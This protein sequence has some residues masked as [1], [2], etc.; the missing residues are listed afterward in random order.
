[1][2]RKRL[3]EVAVVFLLLVGVVV[4]YV[5]RKPV[6]DAYSLASDLPSTTLSVDLSQGT[7]SYT[8]NGKSQTLRVYSIIPPSVEE[9]SQSSSSSALV[10]ARIAGGPLGLVPGVVQF[11]GETLSVWWPTASRLVNLLSSP[12]SGPGTYTGSGGNISTTLIV[13]DNFPPPLSGQLT[14]DLTTPSSPTLSF[15]NSAYTQSFTL[16]GEV[17]P[18]ISSFDFTFGTFS[19][20]LGYIKSLSLQ[21]NNGNLQV[22]VN[23]SEDWLTVP[24]TGPGVYSGSI[25][26][27]GIKVVLGEDFYPL[28]TQECI[29]QQDGLVLTEKDEYVLGLFPTNVHRACRKGA[30][31]FCKSQEFGDGSGCDNALIQSCSE[32]KVGCNIQRHCDEEG[33]C[34]I[35]DCISQT[36][37]IYDGHFSV[38][39]GASY[40]GASQIYTC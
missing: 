39:S 11:N 38:P 37:A 25:L 5:Y 34:D 10:V 12:Y 9:I 18:V 33:G 3:L 15:S 2:N 35:D 1:M 30:T 21:L 40:K 22:V 32:D 29:G 26:Q 36:V 8:A 4:Y 7:G 16:E 14:I 6:Y 28:P 31:V 27:I 19:S 24:Y 13:G 23:S 20:S 17:N